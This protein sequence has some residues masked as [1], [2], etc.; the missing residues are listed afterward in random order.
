MPAKRARFVALTELVARLHHEEP[1]AAIRDGRVVVN[2]SVVW[3]PAARVRSDA[4]IRVR[5]TAVLRGSRKLRTALEAFAATRLEGMIAADI[6]A[7]AGGFTQALLEAGV[8]R[9]YAV[10]AGVGQLQ[11]QLRADPRVIDLERTNLAQLDARRIPEP[12][13]VITVDL[14]YLALAAA[15]P[16]LRAL[17]LS[18]GAR[19]LVLVKPTFELR[20][21]TL[22]AGDEQVAEAVRRVR[23][24]LAASR[25][26]VSP[27]EVSVT[28]A[29]GAVEAFLHARAP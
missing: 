8:A 1:A 5:A 12:L 25:W 11:G 18:D 17:Q 7:A 10:D 19:L 2:G 22:A 20:S 15:I 21:A 28:G 29:R 3:N 6:G 4:S 24:A 14:S 23:A 26:R 13:D 9:V 16:Q 27:T